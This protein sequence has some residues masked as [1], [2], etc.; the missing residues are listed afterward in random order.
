V[1]L[2]KKTFNNK[3]VKSPMDKLIKA[4]WVFDDILLAVDNHRK[5][6]Q[7]ITKTTLELDDSPALRI[8]SAQD[9][10]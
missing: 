10:N 4:N 6:Y 7:Q 3:F 9:M 5:N 8:Q 1:S 2:S